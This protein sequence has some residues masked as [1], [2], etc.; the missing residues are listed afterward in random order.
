M[1]G[2]SKP[3]Q[4]ILLMSGI[5]AILIVSL[6]SVR[7]PPSPDKGLHREIGQALAA[8][9][10]LVGK[11][12]GSVTVITRDTEAF[13]QPALVVLLDSFKSAL[14]NSPLQL[15]SVE[16]IQADPLRP[17]DV[18]PGD[19]FELIRKAKQG[20]VIVS[21]LGP[22]LLTDQ[23]RVQLGTPKPKIVAFCP[24]DVVASQALS[25]L[26]EAGLLHAAVIAIRPSAKA[27][28]GQLGFKDLY[29]VVTE[30]DF[31]TLPTEVRP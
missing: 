10:T 9:V 22:P 14:K 13:H 19:F 18:P 30:K 2:H 31:K 1:P 12:G 20:D 17:V 5:L 16:S 11:P 4:L 7:F 25:F 6:L 8:L 21:F 23:Q 24:G 26:F 29:R 15:G 3:A 28:E 27:A